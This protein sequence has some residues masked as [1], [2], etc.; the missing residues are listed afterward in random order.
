MV[1]PHHEKEFDVAHADTVFHDEREDQE[2]TADNK[3]ADRRR[4][5]DWLN[6]SDTLPV[7]ADDLPILEDQEEWDPRGSARST[8]GAGATDDRYRLDDQDF[9]ERSSRLRRETLERSGVPSAADPRSS[10]AGRR[11]SSDS[12]RR[13]RNPRIDDFAEERIADERTALDELPPRDYV[14]PPAR[15]WSASDAPVIE[16]DPVM[17][18]DRV[19]S[20]GSERR[21]TRRATQRVPADEDDYVEAGDTA[22]SP[23][24]EADRG[25]GPERDDRSRQS[26]GTRLTNRP[27]GPLMLAVL[28]LFGSIGFNIYLGWIAWDLYT[29]YQEA[30][31]DVHELEGKLE[32]QQL[33]QVAGLGSTRRTNSRQTVAAN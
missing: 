15:D 2:E 29:R 27:W 32:E 7:D 30:V 21:P 8:L 6:E 4:F 14:Q 28:G 9:A 12:D 31:S 13:Q 18:R 19:T 25:L 11:S 20:D 33:E 10:A 17:V 5:H 22:N 16:P 1:Q 23:S 26:D 3:G 24:D